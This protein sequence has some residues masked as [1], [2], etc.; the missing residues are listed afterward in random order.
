MTYAEAMRRY[1]SDKPDLRIDLELVDIASTVKGCGF[2]VFAD[3]A[4]NAEGGGWSRC[5]A[6]AGRRCRASRS[7]SWAR[8]RRSSAPRAWPG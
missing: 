4:A 7:T 8:M 2:K 6:R 5:G 3:W 1:G